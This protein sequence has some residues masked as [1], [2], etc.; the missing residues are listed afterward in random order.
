MSHGVPAAEE[1]E[2]GQPRQTC[3]T[4]IEAELLDAS[5]RLHTERHVDADKGD[6]DQGS[7]KQSIA[8]IRHQGSRQEDGPIL[9][10]DRRG[11]RGQNL[12]VQD[13]S[14]DRR[15][16]PEN[17]PPAGHRKDEGGTAAEDSRLPGV[18]AARAWHGGD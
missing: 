11:E 17:K 9:P 3:Y 4:Q 18:L 10:A 2:Y 6:D 14:V 15:P 5:V 1:Q 8:A 12:L 7:E 13:A 16:V